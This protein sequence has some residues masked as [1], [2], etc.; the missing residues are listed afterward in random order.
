MGYTD[1]PVNKVYV[2]VFV[3]TNF[4]CKEWTGMKTVDYWSGAVPSA[5]SN[6]NQNRPGGWRQQQRYLVEKNFIEQTD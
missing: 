1:I 6:N 5:E 4:K 2:E 3:P